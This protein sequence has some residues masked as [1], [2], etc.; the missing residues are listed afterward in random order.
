MIAHQ[1][2]VLPG[3]DHLNR[4]FVH[5]EIEELA[6][7]RGDSRHVRSRH[8]AGDAPRELV[9]SDLTRLA[10]KD[11]SRVAYELRDE[12]ERRALRESIAAGE[13]DDGSIVNAPHDL[14]A[15]P[16][17]PDSRGTGDHNRP[18]YALHEALLERRRQQRELVVAANAWTLASEQLARR[19]DHDSLGAQH[20][21][22]L[23]AADLETSI[24][25]AR[26]RV[27]NADLVIGSGE[28]RCRAVDDLAYG[29]S[30]TDARASGRERDPRM[31]HHAADGE[32]TASR[33]RG[34][35]R[36][37][38]GALGG[39]DGGAIRE[40]LN[41]R[42]PRLGN[43]AELDRHVG[44]DERLCK[45]LRRARP[46]GR[47]DREDTEQALLACGERARSLTR[48]RAREREE[49]AR[50]RH[51][52]GYRHQCRIARSRACVLGEHGGD[53][54]IN[55]GRHVGAQLG[56]PRDV[57]DE[58][59]AE[60]RNEAFTDEGGAAS[61][62]LE[63]D[64]PQRED[65]CARID[66]GVTT[67]LLGRHVA[68]GA[69]DAAGLRLARGQAVVR[70]SEI[71]QHRLRDRSSAEED[72]RRLHVP[73]DDP[74][75]VGDCERSR[76]ALGHDERFGDRQ[77]I[78]REP[79]F[80]ILPLDPL[81]REPGLRVARRAMS[82]VADQAR[83]RELREELGL[84]LEPINLLARTTL[85]DLERDGLTAEVVR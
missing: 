60:D 66:G 15:E 74:A 57:G 36:G 2:R 45:K 79:R 35:V 42:A 41:A 77:T 4:G 85:E 3:R 37:G 5:R 24:E 76:D 54:R 16:G 29:Q 71:E 55:R 53:E 23:V 25:E 1:E 67:R 49:P 43:H 72:V 83:V 7:E 30:L 51:R 50:S 12:V 22:M 26:G 64:A 69:E 84:A 47:G 9:R 52:E 38:A 46:I 27:V 10:R 40:D 80:E 20:E 75:R 68:K 58:H 44:R 70:D 81:H 33:A 62:T 34:F 8:V 32:R 18:R 31:R 65:I 48:R 28:H 21:A 6:E 17:L 78:A 39:N 82:D 59:L 63:E 14:V 19:V 11:A 13:E 73:M 56:D 61:E